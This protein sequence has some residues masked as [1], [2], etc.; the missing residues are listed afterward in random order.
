MKQKRTFMQDITENLQHNWL[1]WVVLLFLLFF[2]FIMQ[3]F[4]GDSPFGEV[5]GDRMMMRGESVRWQAVFIEIYA[6]A[7]L[8]MSYNLMFGFT[9]VISF[10]HALFYGLGGYLMALILEY[11]GLNANLGLLVSVLIVL[12][13]TGVIGFIV[14]LVSL[15]LRGVYFA[16]FTLA[17]AEMGWLYFRGLGLTNGEDGLAIQNLPAWID[18]TRNRIAVYYVGLALFVFTYVLIRRLVNSPAGTVFQAIRENEERAQAIGYDTLRYKL[19]SITVAGMLASLAGMLFAILSKRAN[20][21][22]LGVGNT[23]DAL[24]MTIIGGVGTFTGP[25]IGASGLHLLDVFLRDA[26]ITIGS[27][28]INIGERWLLLLGFIFVL[29]VL[30][31]PYGVIGTWNRL[32]TRLMGQAD[33]A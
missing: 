21:E 2:P 13:V 19:L 24:L 15:R 28:T 31:F 27:V 20:P 7:I 5:R 26:V 30:V 16:I 17:V 9:G 23:V 10:G 32:R 29:V 1:Q 8:V 18:P 25:V 11:S 33:K 4:T 12:A 14:G 6:L 3:L 22:L